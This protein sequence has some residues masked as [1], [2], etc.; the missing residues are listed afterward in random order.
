MASLLDDLV[1][2]PR[3]GDPFDYESPG[4]WQDAWYQYTDQEFQER[5]SHEF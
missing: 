5:F 3:R 4:A 2:E 1:W